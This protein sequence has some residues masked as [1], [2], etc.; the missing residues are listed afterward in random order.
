VL[1]G[2][3]RCKRKERTGG[4]RILHNEELLHLSS[5][6]I[7]IRVIKMRGMRWVGYKE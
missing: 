3:F 4:W 5:F 2:I 6:S 7:I 1:R